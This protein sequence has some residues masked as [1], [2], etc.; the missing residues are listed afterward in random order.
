MVRLF[1][2]IDI[3]GSTQFKANLSSRP[4]GSRG[5]LATFETF[6]S[7]FPLMLAGEMAM[8]FIDD[9]ETPEVEVWKVLGDEMIFVVALERQNE[10]AP[11]LRALLQTMRL[12][13]ERHFAHLPLRL[14]GAAWVAAFPHPNIEIEIPELSNGEAGRH[15]DFIGPDLD[16]GFRIGKFSRPTSLVLSLDLVELLLAADNADTV[17]LTIVGKETLKGVAFGRPYPII[18]MRDAAVPFDFLPW[19]IEDCPLMAHAAAA[20]PSSPEALRK[21]IDDLRLYLHRMHGIDL[22]APVIG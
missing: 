11:I 16:L 8:A 17:A 14:K 15:I 4:G 6:F 18:W 19:E 9:L 3:A 22:A 10:I 1:L 13:E 5:W 12:F 2:S 7:H 21:A 20:P